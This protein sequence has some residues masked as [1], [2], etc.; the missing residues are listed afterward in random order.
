M[1]MARRAP[2]G[3]ASTIR[4]PTHDPT[5]PPAKPA[6]A[7]ERSISPRLANDT[8]EVRAPNTACPLFVPSAIGAG[9][10]A[11][12]SAGSATSPPPPP[13]ASTSPATNAAAARSA[14]T[15]PVG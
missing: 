12:S 5:K 7:R 1:T 2:G 9:S 4:A 8:A 3:I 6:A 13:M 11:A 10:P 15:G 14:I